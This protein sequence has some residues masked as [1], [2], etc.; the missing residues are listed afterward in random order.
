MNIV[1]VI[2][3]LGPGGAERVATTLCNSW[4][5]K[6]HAVTILKLDSESETSFYPLHHRIELVSLGVADNS[7]S[8]LHAI[9][10]NLNALKIIRNTLRRLQPDCIISF[11]E[12]TNITTII[13]AQG[14]GVPVVIS[15]RTHPPCHPIPRVWRT[16]RCITY[17]FSDVLV[18]QTLETRDIFP[19]FIQ[20]RTFVIPNP[21]FLPR[22]YYKQPEIKHRRCKRVIAVGRLARQKRYDL[23]LEAFAQVLQEHEASLTILGEGPLRDELS[24]KAKNLGVDKWV[25]FRGIVQNPF[26]A[27]RESDLFV[28]SSEYEGFPNALLEAMALGVAVISFDCSAGPSDLISN[29]VNGLLVPPLDTDALARAMNKLLGDEDMRSNLAKNARAVIRQFSLDKIL[30]KWDVAISTA[31]ERKETRKTRLINLL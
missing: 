19:R 16:L 23:L 17:P 14:L 8:V 4:I 2:S 25:H 29:G 21:V 24:I 5:D 10:R 11:V 12:I 13:S 20:N 6:G 15:E 7:T 31:I 3:S 22:M 1:F 28:M 9:K 18:T 27:V 26:D 30:A